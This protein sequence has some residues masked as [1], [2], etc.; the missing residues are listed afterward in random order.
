MEKVNINTKIFGIGLNKTGTTTL[1]QCGRILG[2]RCK[3]VSKKLLEDV[4]LRKDLTS[5]QRIATKY[6]LFEDW[7]WPLIYRELDEMFPGSK[8][9]LTV[10]KNPKVWL[11]SLKRHSMTKHPFK[12]CD[13]LVYGY[14]YPHKR[15]KEHIDF[16]M[17]H[18]SAVRNYFEGRDSDFLEIC[19]ENGDDFEKLCKFLN[20]DI[21]QTPLPHANKASDNKLPKRRYEVNK[22]LSLFVTKKLTRKNLSKNLKNIKILFSGGRKNRT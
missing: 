2:Y 16:Y 3:S 12:D 8:F 18:N 21:P 15:A 5:V 14:S 4:V 6:D 22:I 13:K 17:Q 9:I 20:R 10:R 7:P 19:W 11:E 1:G